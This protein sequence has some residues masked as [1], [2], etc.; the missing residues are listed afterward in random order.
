VASYEGGGF[1]ES[2]ENR[3]RDHVEH[4]KIVEKYMSQRELFAFRLLMI[5]TLA[6]LRGVIA[7][8]RKLAGVYHLLK[9]LIYGR[10]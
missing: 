5:L 7:G 3:R 4:K 6:P 9:R 8:N 1:S 10:N 2:R